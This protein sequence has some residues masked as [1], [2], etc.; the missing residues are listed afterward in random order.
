MA[1]RDALGNW[2]V[3]GY[4]QF[5]LT[6]QAHRWLRRELAEITLKDVGR[7][8]F[9]HVT[10]GGEIDEIPETR[11]E[12]SGEYAFHHDLRVMIGGR[13]VYIETRLHYRLP[14]VADESWILVVNVHAC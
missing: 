4:I 12:W 11:P 2:S 13:P 14:V 6:E 7:L 3:T 9:E 8:M 5:E 10:A 1:Y